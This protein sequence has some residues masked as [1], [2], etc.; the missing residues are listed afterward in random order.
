MLVDRRTLAGLLLASTRT[1]EAL[2]TTSRKPARPQVDGLTLAWAHAC[3][4]GTSIWTLSASQTPTAP[5]TLTLPW[6]WSACEA[7]S[8][9][10]SLVHEG[11][12]PQLHLQNEPFAHSSSLRHLSHAE[13]SS[14]CWARA[15]VQHQSGGPTV[16]VALHA[17]ARNRYSQSLPRSPTRPCDVLDS[18]SLPLSNHLR[19][20][21]AT[22]L[23]SS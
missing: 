23:L 4:L 1:T 21:D 14:S 2:A 16:H 19:A 13:L 8:V 12:S 7:V 10:L 15:P 5:S 17:I 11:D 22:P 20:G 9:K 3:E 18:R 6:T